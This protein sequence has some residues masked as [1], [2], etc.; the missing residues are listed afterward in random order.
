MSEE[1]SKNSHENLRQW[2]IEV[3]TIFFCHFVAVNVFDSTG[4]GTA[5]EEKKVF[6]NICVQIDH[7]TVKL[8]NEWNLTDIKFAFIYTEMGMMSLF[9]NVL[10]APHWIHFVYHSG[11][12]DYYAILRLGFL[13][14]L[15]G[16]WWVFM[17]SHSQFLFVDNFKRCHLLLECSRGLCHLKGYQ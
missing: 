5:L 9:S 6:V 16:L 12:F 15:L 17:A 14:R 11:Q 7:S 13:L 3:L 4:W 8:A 10:F 2:L 1:I